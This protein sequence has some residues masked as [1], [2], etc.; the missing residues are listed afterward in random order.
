M[1]LLPY[2]Y[3]LLCLYYQDIEYIHGVIYSIYIYILVFLYYQ[4]VEHGRGGI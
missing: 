4:D 2:F 3:I 1:D